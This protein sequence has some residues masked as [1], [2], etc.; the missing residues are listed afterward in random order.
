MALCVFLVVLLQI[1]YIKGEDTAQETYACATPGSIR[2]GTVLTWGGNLLVEYI[3]D[4]GFFPI[5]DVFG[6]CIEED[7]VW[8]IDSPIC[9]AKGCPTPPA[10]AYGYVSMDDEGQV[11][12][13]SCGR[14]QYLLGASKVFCEGNGQW[15]NSSPK[16]IGP[17]SGNP[18]IEKLRVRNDTKAVSV[19]RTPILDFTTE[20]RKADG[21]CIHQRYRKPPAIPNA[22]V[23]TPYHYD[24]HKRIWVIYANYTCVEGYHLQRNHSRYLFC[25]SYHW[26]SPDTPVCLKDVI[27]PCVLDNGN[28]TQL[29]VPGENLEYFCDCYRGYGLVA[30]GK[31]CADIDECQDRRQN[32]CPGKCINTPGSFTCNCSIPGYLDRPTDKFCQDVDECQENNGNCQEIC[33]NTIGSYSCEC[34]EGL[35]IEEDGHNCTDVNECEEYGPQI[36]KNGD[37]INWSGVYQCVCHRGYQQHKDGIHCTDLNECLDG[38]NGGCQDLCVNTVGSFHCKCSWVGYQLDQQGTECIDIDECT[39]DNGGCENLCSNTYGAYYCYCENE[40]YVVHE[41]GKNCTVCQ[42]HQYID[43]K[44]KWCID[45]PANSSASQNQTASSVKDCYCDNGYQGDPG[46]GLECLDI[47]ECVENALNCSE[48]CLNLPGSAVCTCPLGYFLEKDNISCSDI[49]ECQIYDGGCQGTCVNT[50]GSYHC[51]CSTGYELNYDNH[52]CLDIDECWPN[53][54][55]CSHE[56]I[57][58]EG[59]ARCG[60]YLGYNLQDD[61]KSC[62][63]IDECSEPGL[64]LCEDTCMNTIGSYQCLCTDLGYKLSWDDSSCSDINEC[65]E[66]ENDCEDLCINVLGSYRCECTQTG[67]AISSDGHTCED[68]DECQMLNLNLC[69]HRCK[70][71]KGGF[72][73]SCHPGYTGVGYYD[74]LPCSVGYYKNISDMDCLR[75]PLLSTTKDIASVSIQDCICVEGYQ[76]NLALGEQCTDLNECEL[77]NF[78]CEQY[79]YNTEG[80]AK[81]GCR[82]GYQ[83]N[84]DNKNCTDID[85]CVF[86]SHYCI[87]KCIN[88]P[89]TFKC[90]CREGFVIGYDGRYCNDVDE[91]MA[92]HPCEDLCENTWGSYVCLCTELGTI[93]ASDGVSCIASFEHLQCPKDIFVEVHQHQPFAAVTL[94]DLVDLDDVTVIP[95]WVRDRK[96]F[97]VGSTTVTIKTSPDSALND[98]CSFSV[99]V[100]EICDV[101]RYKASNSTKYQTV[102]LGCNK[103]S[104]QNERGKT[105]CNPCFKGTYQNM[106]GQSNCKYCAPGTFQNRTGQSECMLCPTGNYQDEYGQYKC[107]MCPAGMFQWMEGQDVCFYCPVGKYQN[108]SGQAKCNSCELGYY[109]DEIG[110]HR[111][112]MCPPDIRLYP[113]NMALQ[114]Q[115][116]E[117]V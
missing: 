52:T 71:L 50:V 69:K 117:L 61:G 7:G 24:K 1:S 94:P 77:D 12:E 58:L 31:T 102:C 56:C 47:N 101:G 96:E 90:G 44:K 8:T 20:I 76:G 23:N 116:P 35:K 67:F 63:D 104:Y 11:A 110:G 48:G 3:C 30:D 43:E 37:C 70:N 91:C 40:G 27:H 45:C 17:G 14:S 78:G 83:L 112:K 46:N 100:L 85:E 87:D 106:T 108:L 53:N 75:C 73:C 32:L 97:S 21:T 103:G 98:S 6:A 81:C 109:Q 18:S 89:G 66:G 55:N 25:Q 41:N 79:C 93:L 60:C 57:N 15:N 64:P 111:C 72:M 115:C 84:D 39:T 107:K 65:M 86:N 59:A 95:E 99:H 16:C 62:I 26:V 9:V 82:D 33:V 54:F 28:C 22:T 34:D 4:D 68:I 10:P 51:L 92:D 114:Q 74:C 36:C 105:S 2:H 80:S 19:V 13:F 5:G 113:H 29:C 88:L 42:G 38:N 49:D